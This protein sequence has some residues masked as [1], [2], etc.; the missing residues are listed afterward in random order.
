MPMS[1]PASAGSSLSQLPR[2]DIRVG[3]EWLFLTRTLDDSDKQD[4]G[5]LI[6]RRVVDL[7]PDGQIHMDVNNGDKADGTWLKSIYDNQFDLLSREL[8]P[9]EPILYKP[10]FPQFKFPMS[11]GE[12]WDEVVTQSQP[13]WWQESQIG[14]RVQVQASEEVSVPAGHFVTI[15]LHGVYTTPNATV[16]SR[17]WYAP[18][19]GR[20]VKGIETTVDKATQSSVSTQYEL[21]QLNRLRQV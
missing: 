8:A 14:V 17:Y 21:Q 20:S 11:S 15:R 4:A 5:L 12:A 1:P 9:G 16:T 18:A 3:D 13:E 2:P 6:R 19:A 7:L 10:A